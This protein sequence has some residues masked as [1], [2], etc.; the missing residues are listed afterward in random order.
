MQIGTPNEIYAKPKNPF[1]A[2]FI[3]VSNFLDCEIS[4]GKDNADVSIKG[5]MDMVVYGDLPVSAGLSSS[6]SVLVLM[7]FILR[8]YYH[9]DQVTNINLAEYGLY[10]EQKYIGL[11]DGIMDGIPMTS[12][13]LGR[14]SAEDSRAAVLFRARSLLESGLDD[15]L[16]H[17]RAAADPSG[18]QIR[19]II[20]YPGWNYQKDSAMR[21]VLDKLVRERLGK[22]LVVEGTHGGNETGIWSGLHPD[23]DIVSIGSVEENIHTPQERLDLHRFDNMYSLLTAY[24]ER[25]CR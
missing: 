2:G 6:A 14:V 25:L 10:A 19:I 11:D 15:V 4:G 7:G 24:L 17:L 1:V 22:P 18:F 9:L 23:S 20:R 5:E 21:E 8:R 16:R 13:N 3:G 12:N